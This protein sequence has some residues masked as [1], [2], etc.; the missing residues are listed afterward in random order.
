MS[1]EKGTSGFESWG[2]ITLGATT[3]ILHYPE[4]QEEE[5]MMY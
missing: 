3:F 1:G 2:V 5:E 4:G